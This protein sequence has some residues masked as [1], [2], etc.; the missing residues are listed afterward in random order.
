[1]ERLFT[2]V[3]IAP[4]QVC[5]TLYLYSNIVLI[6]PLQSPWSSVTQGPFSGRIFTFPGLTMV[7][8]QGQEGMMGEC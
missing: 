2:L 6:A 4:L 3:L 7:V 8:V 5:S 1:M